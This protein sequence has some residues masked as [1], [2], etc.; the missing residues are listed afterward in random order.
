M[1]DDLHCNSHECPIR[2]SL[3]REYLK[4]YDHEDTFHRMENAPEPT[5]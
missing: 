1:G 4:F 3:G 2:K 5:Y